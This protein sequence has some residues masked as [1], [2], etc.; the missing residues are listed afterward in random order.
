[1]AILCNAVGYQLVWLIAVAGAARDRQWWGVAAAAV[2]AGLVL[3]HSRQRAA[4]L[5]LVAIALA[6]GLLLDGGLALSGWLQYAAA[7]PALAAP[8]WIL[9]I[10][11]AFALT[12][13]HSLGFLQGRP[14]WAGLIGAIGGPLAYLAAARGFAAVE[15][16]APAYRAVCVLVLAWAIALPLLA[17]LAHAWRVLWP[18]ANGEAP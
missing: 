6:L 11:A 8:A 13:N 17:E 9:A 7:Q 2:F 5:L 3:L 10:W 15:F 14:A 1:M 4:D 12:I 16:A 18:A